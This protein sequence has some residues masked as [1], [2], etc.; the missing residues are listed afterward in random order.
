V[1]TLDI[2]IMYSKAFSLLSKDSLKIDGNQITF[3]TVDFQPHPP[4]LAPI[5]ANLDQEMNL[6]IGSFNFCVGSLGSTRL[7]DPIESGPSARDNTT[8]ATPEAPVGSSSE[9]N[10]SVSIKPTKGNTVEGLDKI[11]ENL[12]LEESSGHQDSGS[13]KNSSKSNRYS[14]EDFMVYYGNISNNSEGTWKSGLELYDD[15]QT[16]FSSGSNR[17]VHSQY[18]VYA[19]IGDSSKEFDG[20][21]NPIINPANVRRGANHMA[22]GDTSESIANRA[23]IQLTVEESETIKAAV[24]E[25]ADTPVD[26]RRDVLLGYHYMLHRQAQQLEKEKSIIRK[27]RES[28]SGASKALHA[29]KATLRTSEDIIGT[30]IGWTILTTLIKETFHA[31]S[32]HLSCQSM[33]EGI[34]YQRHPKR[35]P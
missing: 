12:G 31:T 25:G 19:I 7:S 18:Q 34:S 4:T 26:A 35:H 32:T 16:T 28:A 11:I 15:E 3:G 9:A 6:T 10:S 23:K 14:E 22:E 2:E 21:N 5:F 13:D 20:N 27:K 24:N 29:E 17:D 8:M 33:N 1:G 30:D